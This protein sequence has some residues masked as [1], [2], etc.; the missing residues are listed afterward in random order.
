MKK[1][2]MTEALLLLVLVQF[3]AAPYAVAELEW[4]QKKQFTLDASPLDVAASADGKWFFVLSKGEI[5]VYSGQND[6]LLSRIPV[7]SSFD[8][9][10]YVQPDNSVIVTSSTDKT[11]KMI[12][13]A[14]VHSFSEA[15]L[16]FQGGEKAP[17]TL[18]VFS[19]YQ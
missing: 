19:D 17:V 5:L 7:D 1:I 4:T 3:S 2:R 12:E 6:K 15:G 11:V 8:S 13:L 10:A 14:V 9:I 16:P 18:A